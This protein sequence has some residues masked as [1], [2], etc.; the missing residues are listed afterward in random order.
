MVDTFAGVGT[1]NPFAARIVNM[2]RKRLIGD[3]EILAADLATL[4]P[5]HPSDLS[6][7]TIGDPTN[8]GG[9]QRAQELQRQLWADE[10]EL[11][12]VAR[13]REYAA[14]YDTVPELKRILKV[15]VSMVDRKSV[16]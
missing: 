1:E 3:P 7:T 12:R 6:K 16:V 8:L 14:M 5:E 9:S 4:R 13:Y 15:V 11:G 2:V 10:A